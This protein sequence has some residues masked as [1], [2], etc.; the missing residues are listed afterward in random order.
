VSKLVVTIVRLD[1]AIGREQHVQI[2]P[3]ISTGALVVKT[4]IGFAVQ[5]GSRLK[6]KKS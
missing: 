6:L 5:S 1:V 3:V 2:S 4:A